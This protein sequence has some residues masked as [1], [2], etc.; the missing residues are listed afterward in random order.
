VVKDQD[1]RNSDKMSGQGSDQKCS[2]DTKWNKQSSFLEYDM[3]NLVHKL[4]IQNKWDN[5]KES[6]QIK[7]YIE[8]VIWDMMI[9]MMNSLGIYRPKGNLSHKAK[10]LCDAPFNYINPKF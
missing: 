10:S 3:N 5:I 4:N 6:I 2:S 7:S 1:Q 8:C 9:T